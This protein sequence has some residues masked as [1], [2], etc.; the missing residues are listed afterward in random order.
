MASRTTWWSHIFPTLFDME[1]NIFQFKS[2][3]AS[4]VQHGYLLFSDV[5]EYLLFR[6]ITG[7]DAVV[8]E[9]TNLADDLLS[10]EIQHND[11]RQQHDHEWQSLPLSLP[12]LT[13]SS[14]TI[15]PQTPPGNYS[16][17][18]TSIVFP[19]SGSILNHVLSI[20][21][22]SDETSSEVSYVEINCLDDLGTNC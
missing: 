7:H 10:C 20:T 19:A 12:T 3:S 17:H 1:F 9:E 8:L 16:F 22:D 15:I 14:T 2:V 4:S 13:S 11:T 18:T 6:T 21:T 5:R